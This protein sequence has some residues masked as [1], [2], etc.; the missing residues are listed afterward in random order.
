MVRAIIILFLFTRFVCAQSNTTGKDLPGVWK[1]FKYNR[2]IAY[3]TKSVNHFV[4]GK[5]LVDSVVLRKAEL[6]PAQITELKSFIFNTNTYGTIPISFK[7]GL[8][9]NNYHLVFYKD[10]EII[11]FITFQFDSNT[12]LTNYKIPA[13]SEKLVKDSGNNNYFLEGE[14]FS[15][16][17]KEKVIQLL[18]KTGIMSLD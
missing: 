17:G 14:G 9:C 10:K 13:R 16:E 3:K 11:A 12:L 5:V 2:V 4:R 6:T 7:S 8:C 18:Q 15:K 1:D